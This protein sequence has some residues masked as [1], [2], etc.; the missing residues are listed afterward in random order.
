MQARDNRSTCS[1]L[2]AVYNLK[3]NIGLLILSFTGRKVILIE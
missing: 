2:G 1:R 3:L